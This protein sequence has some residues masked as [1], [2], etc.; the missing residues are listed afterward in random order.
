M[1]ARSGNIKHVRNDKFFTKNR[2]FFDNS[3][4]YKFNREFQIIT[5]SQ[6]PNGEFDPGSG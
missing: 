3:Y 2:S 4:D 1:N 5:I 6:E